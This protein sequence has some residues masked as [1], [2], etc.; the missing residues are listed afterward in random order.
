LIIPAVVVGGL[1]IGIAPRTARADSGSR[2]E[3]AVVVV[4]DGLRPDSVTEQDT[5][6]LFHLAVEGTTFA[7]NHCVY[8]SSTEV[9]GTALAT[10]GYP[11]NSGIVANTEYR[12]DIDPLKPFGTE[13]EAA[14]RKGDDLTGG[15][16]IRLPTMAEILQRSG[17]WTVV[18]GS[19]PVALLLDRHTRS[20][21]VGISGVLF[22]G[23]T[24]PENL[25]SLL[26]SSRGEFPKAADP[27]AAANVDQDA[28]TTKALTEQ[29]WANGVPA[30]TMVW[31][32]EPD[33]AQHGSG[34][35]SSVARSALRSCDDNLDRILK[36]L[37]ER[38]ARDKT[39]VFVVSDHGFS[40]ISRAID[41]AAIL[42]DAGFHAFRQFPS[43]PAI[44][45]VMVIG[46]G[47]S[48]CLYVE[49]HDKR[50]I[51]R[52]VEFLQQSDFAGVI[53]S[54]FEIEGTFPLSAANVDAP[55]A[56][57]IMVSLRW[58]ADR[59]RAGMPGM[60]ASDAKKRNPGQGIHASL[61]RFDM[62][63]TLIAAGP[64]IRRGFL[65][66]LPSGNA[67]VA[68]TVLAVLGVQPPAEMD[69][70]VLEEALAGH[71]RYT[72]ELAA[73]T[74]EA[75]HRGEKLNWRQYLHVTR[76]GRHVYL[77]D[78]NGETRPAE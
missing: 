64:S 59:S 40:T 60:V 27:T 1:L 31:L 46:L 62:H 67:D 4:W 47:G 73:E 2:A 23:K 61:S 15:R 50:T 49:G 70:R 35:N 69:G 22:R 39:N 13:S 36:S 25:D 17:R 14:V 66:T 11:R 55:T 6:T 65:D 9:N 68:P 37:D 71:D 16:Y 51:Q 42:N 34:P 72:C 28:W 41:A 10:G 77:D 52:I 8:V 29:L 20:E 33:Y 30:L 45:D 26:I 63:N 18:A 56:P 44:G 54:R 58:S 7:N 21:G 12:A 5:P 32:S 43:S 19:K 24:L 3:H 38:R 53:F 78:G 75:T 74:L 76:L 57:D 48:V